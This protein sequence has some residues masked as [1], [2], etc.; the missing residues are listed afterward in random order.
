MKCA[1][2]IANNVKQI[3]L[4]PENDGEKAIL[5]LFGGEQ[6]ITVQQKHGTVYDRSVGQSLGVQVG[7][8]MGNY[9]RAYES[10]ESLMLVIQPKT[11]VPEAVPAFEE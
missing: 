8:S 7:M 3:C 9:L 11:P 1:V 6:E 4:T 5:K 10:P 2:I